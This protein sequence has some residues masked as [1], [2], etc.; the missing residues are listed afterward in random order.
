M[1]IQCCSNKIDNTGVS[2]C[3]K[4]FGTIYK[5]YLFPIKAKDGSLNKITLVNGVV[6]SAAITALINNPDKTKRLYPLPEDH[7]P[8]SERAEPITEED[9]LGNTVIVRQAARTENSQFWEK[10][11]AYLKAL[12][13]F[14]KLNVGVIYVDVDGNVMG[15]AATD[16][17]LPIPI[18]SLDF[19][20]MPNN[21]SEIA[22][23]MMTYQYKMNVSDEDLAYIGYEAFETDMTNVEG[24]LTA[25]SNIASI[26]ATPALITISIWT[27]GAN[28]GKKICV[29][30]LEVGDFSFA[31]VTA[32]NTLT[33]GTLT[34]TS[35]GTYEITVTANNP[36][37]G[38]DL[39][40]TIT[41]N[42]FDF[43]AINDLEIEVVSGT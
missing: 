36:T 15:I 4:P 25:T 40:A 5:R 31:N 17:I 9:T 21:G 12:K 11:T 34:E 3:D 27:L 16:G 39:T 13:T 8:E 28:V 14:T 1:T 35:D 2:V 23:I 41:K 20:Y 42:G 30:G 43:S 24:L 22:K 19:R 26:T 6:T 29:T 18:Q 37:V 38:D 10:S 7:N 33:L 32:A